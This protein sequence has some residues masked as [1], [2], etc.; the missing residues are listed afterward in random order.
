MI[1]GKV[2][3]VPG[4]E[5]EYQ[6]GYFMGVTDMMNTLIEKTQP[7]IVDKAII[8]GYAKYVIEQQ[9]QKENNV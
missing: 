8:I 4:R 7:E 2:C 6:R 9:L 5:T 3:I 1:V